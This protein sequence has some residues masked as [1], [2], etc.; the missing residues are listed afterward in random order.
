MALLLKVY[1]IKNP[2]I[3][4]QSSRKIASD[5]QLYS[6]LKYSNVA[7]EKTPSDPSTDIQT[8]KSVYELPGL[9]TIAAMKEFILNKI[10][11]SRKKL[12]VYRG[13]SKVT[14]FYMYFNF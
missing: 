13:E 3:F 2:L 4:N 9:N 11:M 10:A 8:V 1:R 14:E 12:P 7:A 5:I 6:S